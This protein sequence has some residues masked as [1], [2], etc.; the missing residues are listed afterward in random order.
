[1]AEIADTKPKRLRKRRAP[2][3]LDTAIAY[4]V[5]D[6]SHVSGLSRSK[7]FGLIKDGKI[8]SVF[9]CGRRLIPA[10]ALRELVRAA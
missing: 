1:M 6:A 2:P 10:D 9:V 3:P 8:R 7:L 5:R 4:T